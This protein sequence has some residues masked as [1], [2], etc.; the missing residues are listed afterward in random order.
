MSVLVTTKALAPGE[1]ETIEF[2]PAAPGFY[3]FLC[4]MSGHADMLN[5]KGI[6]H[7]K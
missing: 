4:F 7:V 1:S 3:P 5:M 2:K 6:L